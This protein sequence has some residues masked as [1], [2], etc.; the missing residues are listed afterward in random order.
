MGLSQLPEPG[1]RHCCQPLPQGSPCPQNLVP[2]LPS[3]DTMCTA[4]SFPSPKAPMRPLVAPVNRKPVKGKDPT[5]G[6][7]MGNPAQPKGSMSIL[8]A[9]LVRVKA[10]H[11]P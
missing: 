5:P 2:E 11:R 3:Y 10:A 1:P 9:Q 6:L 7:P 8:D 4:T